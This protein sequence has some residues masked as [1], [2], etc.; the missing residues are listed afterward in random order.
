L[1]IGNSDFEFV[2]DFV[3][4]ISDFVACTLLARDGRTFSILTGV[5]VD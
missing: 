1:N 2:S 5:A 3:L 4:R